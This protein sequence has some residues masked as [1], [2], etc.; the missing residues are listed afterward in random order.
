MATLSHARLPGVSHALILEGV[1]G[2]IPKSRGRGTSQRQFAD[3]AAPG[4]KRGM[5]FK[6]FCEHKVA[7]GCNLSPAMVLLLSS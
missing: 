4:G 7:M 5:T 3:P 1:Q 6:D 2:S